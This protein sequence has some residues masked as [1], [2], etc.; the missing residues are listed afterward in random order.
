MIK[1]VSGCKFAPKQLFTQEKISSKHPIPYEKKVDK[2][3]VQQEQQQNVVNRAVKSFD[4][5]I[6]DFTV[7]H[8]IQGQECAKVLKSRVEYAGFF[9][10]AVIE[11][12][13]QAV[14]EDYENSKSEIK[15]LPVTLEYARQS[16]KAK[17]E[18]DKAN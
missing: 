15:L 5:I 1:P 17:F 3:K 11:M 6:V 14:K 13:K 16:Y 8:E 18:K 2:L 9:I 4:D 12:L 10:L 7:K